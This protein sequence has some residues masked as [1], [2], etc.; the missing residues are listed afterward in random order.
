MNSTLLKTR[1]LEALG[2]PASTASKLG[3]TGDGP[4]YI[5]RGRAVYYR[6][7]DIDAWLDAHRVTST[8]EAFMRKEVVG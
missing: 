7:E 3:M 1:D 8:A 4:A 2:I 6:R 5:K